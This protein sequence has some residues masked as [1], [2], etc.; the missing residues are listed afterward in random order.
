VLPASSRYEIAMEPAIKEF[1]YPK[2][3]ARHL[4]HELLELPAYEP[5]LEGVPVAPREPPLEPKDALDPRIERRVKRALR[6]L[7]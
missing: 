2:E 4:L 6:G 3:A 1:P 7:Q 5:R